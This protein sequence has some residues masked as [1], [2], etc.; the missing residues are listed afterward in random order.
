MKAQG[1]CGV[2]ILNIQDL[3]FTARLPVCEAVKL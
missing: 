3:G 1:Q 2:E